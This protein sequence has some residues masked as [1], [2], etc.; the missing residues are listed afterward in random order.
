MN[1][2]HGNGRVGTPPHAARATDP[3]ASVRPTNDIHDPSHSTSGCDRTLIRHAFIGSYA[4]RFRP[5]PASACPRGARSSPSDRPID[6]PPRP[7]S[8][9]PFRT[10]QGGGAMARFLKTTRACMLPNGFGTPVNPTRT[11]FLNSH[12][13]PEETQ[14][15]PFLPHFSY[16][17]CLSYAAFLIPSLR[18]CHSY[19]LRNTNADLKK[20]EP[21][22]PPAS[23]I[24][25]SVLEQ[26]GL[27]FQYSW[28]K[29]TAEVLRR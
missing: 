27:P 17:H 14:L 1:R 25:S 2:K 23:F 10:T 21:T 24:S 13:P 20:T 9:R 19:M 26:A 29:H 4:A 28:R 7:V 22:S 3:R 6:L 12:S 15:T 18:L 5:D 8:A 11:G 16:L